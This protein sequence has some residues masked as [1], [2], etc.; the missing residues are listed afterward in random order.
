MKTAIAIFL[1]TLSVNCFAQLTLDSVQVSKLIWK[2]NQREE[3]LVKDSLN[4]VIIAQQDSVITGY[5][6]E[7]TNL[8]RINTNLSTDNQW[9]RQEVERL[10]ETGLKWYVWATGGGLVAVLVYKT[11]EMLLK[12]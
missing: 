9:L 6:K 3:L 8:E 1:L 11:I 5:G 2:L 7:V 12:K 4:T 10:K